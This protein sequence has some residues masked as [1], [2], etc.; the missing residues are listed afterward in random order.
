M[1]H[2]ILEGTVDED[3]MASL[4]H[5]RVDQDELINAVKARIKKYERKYQKHET[6][7]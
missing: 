3:V 7:T 5:K 1:H 4:K 2:L 6:L